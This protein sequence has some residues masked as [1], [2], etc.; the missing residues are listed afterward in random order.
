MS[1]IWLVQ[2]SKKFMYSCVKKKQQLFFCIP[3]W[4]LTV[5]QCCASTTHMAERVKRWK[6]LPLKAVKNELINSYA[7]EKK[8]E[9]MNIVD[10][11]DH[12]LSLSFEIEDIKKKNLNQE[13]HPLRFKVYYYVDT[14]STRP[15]I[16]PWTSGKTVESSEY[17][18]MIS[19]CRSSQKYL[20]KN[21]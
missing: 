12:E 1:V 6:I 7:R 3:W 17:S 21:L 19:I 13:R 2:W 8:W 9:E 11:M 4:H 16:L 20:K 14:F 18:S 10:G 5:C 15:M